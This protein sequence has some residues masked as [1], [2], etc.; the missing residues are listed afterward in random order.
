MADALRVGAAVL[1][2]GRST[3]MGRNKM[4]LA[5][6][7]EPMVRRAV[8]AATGAG[9]APIVVVVGH[10]HPRVIEAL[11]GLPCECLVN[12]DPAGP[13]AGSLHLAITALAPRV[14]AI[15]LLLADMIHVDAAMLAT[16]MARAGDGP[17]L[18]ASRYG[19]V[20]APPFLFPRARFEELLALEGEGIGK[21]LLERHRADARFVDWPA[22]RLA[23]IDTPADL[24]AARRRLD[25][26][27]G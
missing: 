27:V 16:L 12:P 15:L 22:D 9:A 26:S 6:E 3:R 11:D 24:D 2:A 8:R 25:H 19:D 21:R 14:D 1:A 7:G 4:L 5:V 20:A 10:E 17:A 23:D 18:L 13:T